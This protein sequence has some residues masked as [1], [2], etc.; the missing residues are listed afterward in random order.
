[1]TMLCVDDD[2]QDVYKVKKEKMLLGKRLLFST[3]NFDINIQHP[4]KPLVVAIGKF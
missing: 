4:C 3:L 1:M 2:V